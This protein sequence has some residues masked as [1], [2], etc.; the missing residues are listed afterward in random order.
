VDPDS[1][2]PDTAQLH[3]LLFS[4]NT[5]MKFFVQE[6]Y[7]DRRHFVWCSSTFDSEKL[8]AYSS[9]RLLPPSSNPAEI[10]RQLQKDVIGQDHHSYKI[11]QQKAVLTELAGTWL[12]NGEISKEQAE[13]I[14]YLLS[15]AS[16][17]S[18]RPLLYVI[19]WD[20]VRTRVQ[21]VPMDQRAGPA[22]EYRISDL[23]GDEFEIVE[24]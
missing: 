8:S 23:H 7:R 21:L 20:K 14:A 9:G 22:E 18:W 24:I 3:Q 2:H 16:F 17:T 1:L 13:E 11:S 10:Y 5:W 19:P 12:Y 15:H 4:T 6:Q